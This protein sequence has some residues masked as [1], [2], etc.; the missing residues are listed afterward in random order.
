MKICL[1]KISYMIH[2]QMKK[3]SRVI[4]KKRV[5]VRVIIKIIEKTELY[6]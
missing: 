3:N 4:V 6:F 1:N 2:K 5:K